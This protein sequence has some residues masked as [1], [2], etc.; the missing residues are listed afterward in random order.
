MQ[1]KIITKYLLHL[2]IIYNQLKKVE[3]SNNAVFTGLNNTKTGNTLI[4]WVF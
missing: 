1:F 2:V 4:I 3:E